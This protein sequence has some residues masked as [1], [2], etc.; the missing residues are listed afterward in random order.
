MLNIEGGKC[1]FLLFP[2]VF[3]C[4]R[5][6]I[7]VCLIV[8]FRH[9]LLHYVNAIK[10]NLASHIQSNH[11]FQDFVIPLCLSPFDTN[12]S[13]IEPLCLYDSETKIEFLSSITQMKQCEDELYRQFIGNYRVCIWNSRRSFSWVSHLY[14]H[15]IYRCEGD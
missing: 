4:F 3:Y 6:P 11:R 2:L 1:N 10:F 8:C 7:F 9:T 15:R 13:I 14:Q 5:K 12:D